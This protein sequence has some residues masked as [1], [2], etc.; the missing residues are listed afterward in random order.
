MRSY[1]FLNRYPDR[2]YKEKFV[3]WAKT[4]GYAMLLVIMF[5]TI[6]F[7]LGG[8]QSHGGTRG[9][10]QAKFKAI[11]QCVRNSDALVWTPSTDPAFI[12]HYLIY[13]NQRSGRINSAK[14]LEGR[15]PIGKT[16]GLQ[17]NLTGK[18]RKRL[19][20]YTVQAVSFGGLK[21]TPAKPISCLQKGQGK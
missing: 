3:R 7:A 10:I 8:T 9:K 1:H 21:S 18:Y 17:F 15:T 16:K 2:N 13:A 12:S 5:L 4:V 14:D 6:Y 20:F 19:Y 11:K